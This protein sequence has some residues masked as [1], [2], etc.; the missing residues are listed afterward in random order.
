MKARSDTPLGRSAG[1]APFSRDNPA[2]GSDAAAPPPK[3]ALMNSRR[4]MDFPF[5]NGREV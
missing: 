3:T 4:C 5:V 2:D 1:F